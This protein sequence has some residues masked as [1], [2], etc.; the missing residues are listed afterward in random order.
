MD[1]NPPTLNSDGGVD[2]SGAEAATNTGA[3][4]QGILDQSRANQVQAKDASADQQYNTAMDNRA[5]WA[6]VATGVVVGAGAALIPGGQ[7]AAAALIVP[8]VAGAAG[9][10]LTQQI[11]NNIDQFTGEQHRDSSEKIQDV[12]QAIYTQGQDSSKTPYQNLIS[13]YPQRWTD[14]QYRELKTHLELAH[15]SGYVAGSGSIDMGGN[16]PSTE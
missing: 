3:R 13:S 2:S 9:S 6:K 7:G 4:V 5:N 10:A 12:R 15:T 16:L 1:Q 14:E 11:S 8:I